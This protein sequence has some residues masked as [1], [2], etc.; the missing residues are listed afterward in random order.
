MLQATVNKSALTGVPVTPNQDSCKDHLPRKARGGRWCDLTMGCRA[1]QCHLPAREAMAVPKRG[2]E[3][4]LLPS[5]STSVEW[6]SLSTKWWIFWTPELLDVGKSRWKKRKKSRG[7]CSGSIWR[8]IFSDICGFPPAW[9]FASWTDTPESRDI[10]KRLVFTLYLAYTFFPLVS[11][12]ALWSL[13]WVILSFM[14]SFW[15]TTEKDYLEFTLPGGSRTKSSSFSIK[16]YNTENGKMLTL[17]RTRG[18]TS[19]N[20][21]IL[22]TGKLAGSCL[23]RNTAF[24]FWFWVTQFIHGFRKNSQVPLLIQILRDGKNLLSKICTEG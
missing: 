17:E 10:R 12:T 18:I 22:W 13:I 8:L 15:S 23:K 16:A 24:P 19:S 1:H 14:Y 20:L 21:F 3:G 11:E 2:R 9:I 6:L 7:C 4:L 5:F